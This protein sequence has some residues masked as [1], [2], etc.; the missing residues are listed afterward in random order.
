MNYEPEKYFR[1]TQEGSFTLSGDL[2][3][4][5]EAWLGYD[6][7]DGKEDGCYDQDLDYQDDYGSLAGNMRVC[8]CGSDL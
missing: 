7:C 3:I 4:C 1:I 6:F 2:H 5:S 8:C